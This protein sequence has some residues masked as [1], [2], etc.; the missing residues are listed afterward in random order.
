MPARPPVGRGVPVHVGGLPFAALLAAQVH[1]N[2]VLALL[3]AGWKVACAIP[4]GW[5]MC[6]SKYASSFAPLTAST[7]SP[8]QSVL[9]PYSTFVPESATS[10]AVNASALPER[11]LPVPVNASQRTMSA[12]QNQ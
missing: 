6:S 2:E 11:V 8:S 1:G 10:G 5:R 3:L 7:T 12:F 9:V 4:S